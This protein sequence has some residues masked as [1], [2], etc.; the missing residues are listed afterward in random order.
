ML[1][2]LLLGI[3]VD[4]NEEKYR[5]DLYHTI[6]YQRFCMHKTVNLQMNADNEALLR[7]MGLIRDSAFAQKD[8]CSWYGVDCTF[9][10]MMVKRINWTFFESNHVATLHWFPPSLEQL[11]LDR[12]AVRKSLEAEYLPQELKFLSMEACGLHGQLKLGKFPSFTEEIFLRDN[13][14]SGKL[15]IKDLPHR[16]RCIDLA[17]NPMRRVLVGNLSGCTKLQGIQVTCRKIQNTELHLANSDSVGS[18]IVYHG[19]CTMKSS[20]KGLSFE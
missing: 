1:D 17:G 13:Q 9:S 19:V 10:C 5:H 16:I 11:T 14:F 7:E 6:D 12:I 4:A 20:F 3:V 8:C 15:L 2:L 18:G